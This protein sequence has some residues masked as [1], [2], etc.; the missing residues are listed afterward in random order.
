MTSDYKRKVLAVIASIP[1]GKVATYGDVAEAAGYPAAVRGVATVLRGT[2]TGVP[3]HRVIAAGGRIALTG[4][5]GLEQ[6]MR[7]ESEGVAFKGRRV[8]IEKHRWKRRKRS[9]AQ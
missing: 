8:D 4:H 5:N 9:A 2:T 6:R 1:R 7:L 3:W